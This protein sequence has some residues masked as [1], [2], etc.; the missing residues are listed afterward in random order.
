[1]DKT[2]Q[3]NLRNISDRNQK[4][5]ISCQKQG[6]YKFQVQITFLPLKL[7]DEYRGICGYKARVLGQDIV[8]RLVEIS[9]AS[10]PRLSTNI[11]QKFSEI[12]RLL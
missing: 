1:M 3:E 2:W 4:K 8:S 12:L 11:T 6:L 10:L 7:Y 9:P 5:N